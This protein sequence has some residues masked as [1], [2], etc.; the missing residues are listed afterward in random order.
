MG[1]LPSNITAEQAFSKGIKSTDLHAVAG[2]HGD[3]IRL[4]K[5]G[6]NENDRHRELQKRLTT[7]ANKLADLE[8]QE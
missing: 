7:E 3:H 2:W 4:T 8:I 5:K 1:F 6:S